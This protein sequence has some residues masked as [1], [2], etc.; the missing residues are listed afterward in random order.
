MKQLKAYIEKMRLIKPTNLSVIEG[1][2]DKLYDVCLFSDLQGFESFN[3]VCDFHSFL[4]DEITV[5]SDQILKINELIEKH[6]ND[7]FFIC[8]THSNLNNMNILVKKDK[9][10]R[11]IDWNTAE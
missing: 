9:I 7:Q 10:V 8:L 5:S 4:R 1:F 11:I 6:E 2:N 3:S